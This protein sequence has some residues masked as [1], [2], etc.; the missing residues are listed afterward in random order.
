[1]AGALANPLES[2]EPRSVHRQVTAQHQLRRRLD[3]EL[4]RE[5]CDQLDDLVVRSPHLA[6]RR[7]RRLGPA[8]LLFSSLAPLQRTR[9]EAPGWSGDNAV[10]GPVR[11]EPL[12][13]GPK[14]PH[15]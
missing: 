9:T 13:A 5:R 12:G 1:M 8:T 10:T 14:D 11:L 15:R 6:I 7:R 4:T 2:T 3:P